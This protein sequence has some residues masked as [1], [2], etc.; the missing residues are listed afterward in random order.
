MGSAG[1]SPILM[2]WI[3]PS[4]KVSQVG[5]EYWYMYL[6]SPSQ[7]QAIDDLVLLLLAVVKPNVKLQKI[8]YLVQRYR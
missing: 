1:I 3:S 8:Q 7:E 5:V 2:R 6:F 4:L